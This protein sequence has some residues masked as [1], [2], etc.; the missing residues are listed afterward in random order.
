MGEAWRPWRAAGGLPGH[1]GSSCG[2]A[3]VII[4]KRSSQTVGGRGVPGPSATPRIVVGWMPLCQSSR[5]VPG[6]SGLLRGWEG[7]EVCSRVPGKKF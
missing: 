3:L 6:E 4:R 1:G 7:K 5:G 2:G